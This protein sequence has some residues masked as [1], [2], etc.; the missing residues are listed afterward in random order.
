M[1]ILQ[2]APCLYPALDY[3]GGAM[4]P[5]ELSKR[6]IERGHEVTVYTT[7]A[8]DRYSRISAE[9]GSLPGIKTHYFRN[10]NNPLAYKYKLFLSPGM[11]PVAKRE[12]R[13]FDIVHVHILRTF[14]SIVIRHYAKRYEIPYIIQPHGTLNRE[15]KAALKGIFDFVFGYNILRDTSRVIVL[16]ET[17]RQSCINMGVAEDKIEIIPTAI[18]LA[19][20]N[21]LPP[22]GTFRKKYGVANNAKVILYLGRIHEGKGIDLLVKAFADIALDFSAQLIIIGVDDGYLS[23]L[24]KLI[25][26]LR[27]ENKVKYIGFVTEREKKAAY[28][29]A[30]IFVSPSFYGFPATFLEAMACGTPI[31]TTDKGDYIDGIDNRI[32][33]VAKFDKDQLVGKLATLLAKEELREK[34][35]ENA[36][37]LVKAYDWKAIVSR[38]EKIYFDLVRLRT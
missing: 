34:F 29:D 38:F 21:D 9:P 8:L 23:A 14:Q 1:R 2:V 13:N 15:A 16:N 27:I 30:D 24:N 5:Y 18:D 10:V 32:G 4:M 6:L 7:D 33:Y 17:E 36:K 20:Y 25:A 28:V 12:L 35:A 22:K 31:V 11:I 37:H 19:Q 26:S 3:G